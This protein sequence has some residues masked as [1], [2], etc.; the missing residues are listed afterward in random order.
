MLISETVELQRRITAAVEQYTAAHKNRKIVQ[1]TFK[2]VPDP[3]AFDLDGDDAVQRA[4]AAASLLGRAWEAWLKT[5]DQRRQR[6]VEPRTGKSPWI[7]PLEMGEPQVSEFPVKFGERL[8]PQR[9]AGR[10]R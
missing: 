6:S 4:H 5:D 1:P 3:G 2:A 8:H 9:I 10:A 7:M